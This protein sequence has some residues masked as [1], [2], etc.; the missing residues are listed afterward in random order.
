[1]QKTVADLARAYEPTRQHGCFV[2][3]LGDEGVTRGSCLSPQCLEAYQGYLKQEYGDIAALNAEWGTNFGSFAQVALSKP[4]DNNEQQALRD[5]N[6]PRWFDRQAFQCWNLVQYCGKYKDA[7]AAMDPEAKTGFEGTGTLA[8]GDDFDLIVRNNTFWSP[9]PG[10][11]DEIIRSIAPRDFPRANWMGYTRDADS[12]LSKFWRMVTRGMDGVW[13]W[14]WDSAPPF[15]G[16]LAPYGGPYAAVRDI[17]ADTRRI[18]EGLGTLLIRS[19]MQEDGIALLYSHP[20]AYAAKVEAGPTYGTYEG[21]H[22]AWHDLIRGVGLQFGYVTDRQMRLGEFDPKRWKVLILPQAE[23]I[24]P[25]EAKVIRDF[26]EQGG[27]VIADVRPGLYDGHC[28]PLATGALDDLFGVKQAGD[29]PSV[30]ADVVGLN[31]TLKK[32]QANPAVA[33]TDGKSLAKSGDIPLHIVHQ[34][35]KGQAILLNASMS[36]FPRLAAS[37]TPDAVRTM[38]AS[39]LASGGAKPPLDLV[40]VAGNPVKGCEITRWINGDLEIVSLFRESGQREGAVIKLPASRHV[41]DLRAGKYLGEVTQFPVTIV[42]CRATFLVLSPRAIAAPQVS[43]PAPSAKPGQTVVAKLSVP[44][45]AGEH[46]LRIRVLGPDGRPMEAFDQTVI[47]GK[48][49]AECTLPIAF[50]DPTGVW[51]VQARDI[52]SDRVGEA[53]LAVK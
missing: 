28:K 37:D 19:Q 34:G 24:G 14:R 17:A 23:A 38:A 5:R 43:L 32:L 29:K 15:R 45:A 35:G 40:S 49:G 1:V 22:V 25:Q 27:T 39:L 13:W 41:Y 7:F 33:L 2:Y 20:S 36:S 50:N 4:D 44:Q 51:T 9:Y 11:G 30:V 3:S 26:A 46:A 53:K 6:Y 16:L 18:R 21:A 42:P 31:V 12:L 8:D 47:V 48:Q 10:A 52:Y